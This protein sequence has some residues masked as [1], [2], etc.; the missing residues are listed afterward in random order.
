MASRT[1]GG[2]ET[3][4]SDMIESLHQIGL[5]QIAVVP[6]ASIH[7][8]R[9]ADTGVKLA[10]EV[11]DIK[12]GPW[13]RYKLR[14]VIRTFQPDIA[15]CWMRRAAG[16]VPALDIPV[17]GWFG[18]YYDPENFTRCTTFVGVT[19]D[20]VR[21]MIDR[22]VRPDRARYVPTFPTIEIGE[23]VV[24]SD[25]DTPK[26]AMV[27]LALSRLHEEGTGHPSKS[28]AIAPAVRRLDR[29]GWTFGGRA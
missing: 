10:P 1:N 27:L 22:G 20:I 29:R 4:C 18:G 28:Y 16:L 23:A 9:L 19:K 24:R 7:H 3:Y 6:P 11:L 12:F 13:Q 8:D 26:D 21:H 25:L 5:D 14:N 17:I 2:A 15:H